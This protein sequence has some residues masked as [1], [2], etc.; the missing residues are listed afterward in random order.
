MS[1]SFAR[2]WHPGLATATASAGLAYG[3]ALHYLVISVRD[4]GLSGGTWSLRGNGAIILV[5]LGTLVVLAAEIPLA[6]RGAWA[7]VVLLPIASFIGLFVVA[8]TV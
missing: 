4:H 3:I 5:L 2:H 7:G 8:G 1:T 6:R